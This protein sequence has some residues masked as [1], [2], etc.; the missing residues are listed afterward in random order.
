LLN[1]IVSQA[2]IRLWDV[3]LPGNMNVHHDE[4]L[5][6]QHGLQFCCG[7]QAVRASI[8]LDFSARLFSGLATRQHKGA[9]KQYDQRA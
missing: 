6:F 1:L 8:C 9:D 4:I 2:Q 5:I 7:D 3:T